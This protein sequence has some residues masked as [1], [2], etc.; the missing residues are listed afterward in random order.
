[1]I[2]RSSLKI[3][4]KSGGSST[5]AAKTARITCRAAISD[6]F[7][8]EGEADSIVEVSAVVV[9]FETTDE[10]LMIDLHFGN[11]IE[12]GTTEASDTGRIKNC[13]LI[14]NADDVIMGIGANL[15]TPHR[16]QHPQ[17]SLST[18]RILRYYA[19]TFSGVSAITATDA[20]LR[21]PS[22][23]QLRTRGRTERLRW[24]CNGSRLGWTLRHCRKWSGFE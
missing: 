6:P 1:L 22:L 7:A 20:N 24:K 8:A 19:S 3:K 17:S 11:L 14:S 15:P 9:V 2:E 13:V 18:L 5:T 4:T 23:I 10:N 16:S 21:T 12:E